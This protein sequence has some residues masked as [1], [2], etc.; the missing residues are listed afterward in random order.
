MNAICERIGETEKRILFYQKDRCVGCGL[1]VK[2]CPVDAIGLGPN[3]AISR[4]LIESSN[5]FIDS[6]KCVLCGI[7]SQVC[8]FNAVDI[9]IDGTSVKKLEGY[10]KYLKTFDFD[11]DKCKLKD[12]K[13]RT[14]CKDCEEA[15]P[16]EAIKCK[17]V[18]RGKKIKNTIEHDEDLCIYCKV[19]EKACPEY[20]INVEK[21]IDG[22][23]KVDL[24]RCQGCGVCTEV[25]PSNSITMPKS[26]RME[27]EVDNVVI[28]DE[29]C[30]FCGACEN[31]CP[32]HAIEVRRTG[33]KYAEGEERPWTRAYEEAFDKLI[34]REDL[35][36]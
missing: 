20:A 4:G 18:G 28:G 5:V 32:V 34:S 9:M 16:R 36:V 29:T 8:L 12:R 14:I 13:T 7:C 21:V 10:P 25:C 17:I 33:I 27:E 26:E 3:G 6:E 2:A 11:Q 35:N 30:V 23:I 22:D 15:C 31:A 19:C 1:C 24:E